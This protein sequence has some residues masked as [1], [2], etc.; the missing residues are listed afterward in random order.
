M[1]KK[2][3]A[4]SPVIGVMLMLV[5]TLLIAGAVTL[6]ATG[7]LDD[8]NAASATSISKVKFIGVD[9]AGG[10]TLLNSGS[11]AEYEDL[12]GDVGL[13]FEVTGGDPVDLRNLKL[14]LTDHP[15]HNSPNGRYA[16]R[17]TITYNDIPSS[18][19]H[20]DKNREN[21]ITPSKKFFDYGVRIAPYPCPSNLNDASHIVHPG[22]K[23]LIVAEYVTKDGTI[24][25]QIVRGGDST[26][27]MS[28][29]YYM[30]GNI[31][32]KTVL[33]L[34]DEVSGNVL[35]ECYLSEGVIL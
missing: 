35:V 3:D 27:Y 18:D 30:T 21:G 20:P 7:L 11:D 8:T 31:A 5:V 9:T 23:F 6:F 2:D 32:E 1:V 4:V 19:Y 15:T 10:L 24:G 16:G 33:T 17:I 14:T 13:V 22:E 34:T 12:T 26:T 28:G 25:F 29:K